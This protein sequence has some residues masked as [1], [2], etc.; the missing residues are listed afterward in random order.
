MA[1]INVE[2][3][4]QKIDEVSGRL[5]MLSYCGPTLRPNNRGAIIVDAFKPSDQGNAARFG[6][7]E[8]PLHIAIE[9]ERRDYSRRCFANRAKVLAEVV[10]Q[11]VG[12][13]SSWRRPGKL[14]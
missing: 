13:R 7:K 2:Q 14:R 12:P 8:T 10:R 3:A 5:G 9:L 1:G 11:N 6:L 4:A